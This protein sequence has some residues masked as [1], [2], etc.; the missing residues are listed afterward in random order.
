MH[1]TQAA[2]RVEDAETGRS[3]PMLMP[4]V[5]HA[6]FQGAQEVLVELRGLSV[7]TRLERRLGAGPVIWTSR[8]ARPRRRRLG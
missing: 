6:V 3:M 2:D 4:P 1:N 8:D 7:A 5:G